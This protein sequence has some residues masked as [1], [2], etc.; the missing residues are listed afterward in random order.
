M[1]PKHPFASDLTP[2]RELAEFEKLKPR[3][4]EVWDSISMRDEEP[5]TSVVVPSLTLDQSELRKLE[6][7]SYYEERL[8]F[9]LI[10]LRN[11]RARVVFVTSQ[12]VHPL[13]LELSLIHI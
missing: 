9:L 7:S 4:K 13:V 12:P 3:L 2:E 1:I 5:H 8:L 6:G 11:P 10:R